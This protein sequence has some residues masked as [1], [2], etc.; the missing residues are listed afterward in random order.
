MPISQEFLFYEGAVGNNEVFENRSSGAY[1]FR[2][3]GTNAYPVT[4]KAKF[5]IYTGYLLCEIHQT[6]NEWTS[7]IIRIYSKENY[8]EFDWVVGPLPRSLEDLK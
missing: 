2:P 4:D 3:N 8:V 1:I 7:Q 6:F 5:T